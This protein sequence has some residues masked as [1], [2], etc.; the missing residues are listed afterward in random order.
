MDEYAEYTED[1]DY[2]VGVDVF[3]RLTNSQK[4]A[5][6]ALVGRALLIKETRP[7]AL[8]A[9]SEGTVAALF[10]YLRELVEV[11]LDIRTRSWRP[12]ILAACRSRRLKIRLPRPGCRKLEEWQFCIECLEERILWD[13]DWDYD[14]VQQ[15]GDP[16]ASA[17]LSRLFGI[18]AD[19]Y[20]AIAPDPNDRELKQIRSRLRKLSCG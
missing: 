18:P 13:A 8:T 20:T 4:L 17:V 9:V 14:M 3:D 6:L 11:E 19:Y 5:M 7:P 15:D 16:F 12:L 10:A 1:N 2:D